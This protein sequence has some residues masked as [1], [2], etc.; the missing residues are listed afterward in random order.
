MKRIKLFKAYFILWLFIYFIAVSNLETFKEFFLSTLTFNIAI[1]SI[2]AI[3]TF[4]ILKGSK[5]L[6]VIA[7]TFGV[8]M[9]KKRGLAKHIKGI[10]KYFPSNIANKIKSRV[11]NGV[12]LFTIEEKDEILAWIDEKFNNQNKYNN[13][14]IGTVL[15]VGLLGTFTGLLGSIGSMAEIVSSLAGG[16]VDIGEIMANFSGPLSSMAVGFGSSLFGVIS[17]ILLS[18]KGYLL[19]K[20]QATLVGGVENWLNSCTLE[21]DNSA[22]LTPSNTLVSHQKSFMDVFVEQISTLNHQMREISYTNQ[23]FKKGFLMTIEQVQK[24]YLEQRELL[25]SMKSSM[26]DIARSS[27][28]NVRINARHLDKLNTSHKESQQ[29][30]T[31]I[32]SSLQKNV[33]NSELLTKNFDSLNIT[34]DA[35]ISQLSQKDKI[36]MDMVIR[37]EGRDRDRK[38]EFFQIVDAIEDLNKSIKKNENSQNEGDY[39]KHHVASKNIK[40]SV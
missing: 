7:G 13:F 26:E 20:A 31:E 36:L 6:T 30:L 3:G 15:M 22:A 9:Y 10:E 34:T 16:D 1:V 12:L 24:G 39:F 35:T 40:E 17:A 21:A 14:F 29:K 19:N 25:G 28:Q 38:I 4:M 37:Q 8:L 33:Q 32:F 2:L 5:D 18:I 11:D 27:E 23:E